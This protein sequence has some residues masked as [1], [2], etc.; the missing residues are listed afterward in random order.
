[1]VMQGAKCILN[2][3]KLSSDFLKLGSEALV[4]VVVLLV[5]FNFRDD[6]PVVKVMG[7]FVEGMKVGGKEEVDSVGLFI[8]VLANKKTDP[9]IRVKFDPLG[10][11]I[12]SLTN[13][14]LGRDSPTVVLVTNR[15]DG[16]LKLSIS[17]A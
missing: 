11:G 12:V 6:G 13:G 5:S 7:G 2:K 9:S 16:K 8:M 14:N 10:V 15:S 4:T 3:P 1:V 17:L